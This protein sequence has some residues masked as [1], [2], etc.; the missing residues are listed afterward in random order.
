MKKPA[1]NR[2]LL[3]LSGESLAHKSG[4][5]TACNI[6]AAMLKFLTREIRQ[7]HDMGVEIAIVIGGGNI[8]R[9]EMMARNGT[10]RI[11]G[12]SI[13]MLATVINA[14]AMQD[15]I[16]DSGV[17]ARVM[18]AISIGGVCEDYIRAKAVN[19]LSEKCIVILAA[20]T[21]SPLFTTDTAASLRASEVSAQLVLKA[22]NVNGV[23]D[24]DPAKCA[25]ARL[26]QNLP[27]DQLIIDRLGIMDS[28]AVVMCRDNG[29]P[30]RVFNI[31][32]PGAFQ[33]V[34][35]GE[36]FGTLIS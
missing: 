27:Y 13:G 14:L 29:I 36:S 2:V 23:Y 1:Y 35:S 19:A 7:V 24:Q 15:A 10:D 31:F 11:T 25:D 8:F 32:S 17:D 22:T 6:D 20:G 30:I 5:P 4:T 9:G 12:D 28:T 33:A 3:K 34:V 18:S 21:G 16:R 26:Y